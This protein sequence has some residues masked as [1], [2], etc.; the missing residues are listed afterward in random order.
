MLCPDLCHLLHNKL[1][2]HLRRVAK[3]SVILYL[4]IV[5]DKYGC[6]DVIRDHARAL[7]STLLKYIITRDLLV[8]GQL[9]V[10][11]YLLRDNGSFKIATS[12]LITNVAK[13][14]HNLM[15]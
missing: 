6:I 14:Y 15:G 4:A 9:M 12:H 10:A 2:P 7:L 3:S 5:A 11:A 13:P 1:V 8:N